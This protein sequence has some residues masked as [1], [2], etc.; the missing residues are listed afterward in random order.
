MNAFGICFRFNLFKI[1]LKLKSSAINLRLVWKFLLKSLDESNS[2]AFRFFFCLESSFGVVA[3]LSR[4][5]PS[6]D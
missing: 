6:L 1:L 3:T 2:K 5:H 4:T